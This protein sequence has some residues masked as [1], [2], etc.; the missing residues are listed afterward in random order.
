MRTRRQLYLT[1]LRVSAASAKKKE[2]EGALVIRMR[3][4]GLGFRV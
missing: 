2:T 1:A 3:F 4:W